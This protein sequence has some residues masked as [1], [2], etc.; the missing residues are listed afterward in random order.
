MRVLLFAAALLAASPALATDKSPA[1]RLREELERTA[2]S[3]AGNL[4]RLLS[5]FE[6]VAREFPRYEAPRMLENG[7]IIVRRKPPDPAEKRRRDKMI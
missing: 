1:E 5:T 3:L 4:G 2:E 7:D 6:E